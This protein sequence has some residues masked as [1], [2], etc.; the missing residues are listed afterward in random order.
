MDNYDKGA[1]AELVRWQKK[2]DAESIFIEQ[3]SK[4]ITNKNK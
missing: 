4:E 1:L 2:Y 3:V